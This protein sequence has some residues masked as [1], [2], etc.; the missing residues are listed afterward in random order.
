MNELDR[1]TLTVIKA[2]MLGY[3]LHYNDVTYIL[4][5][6]KRLF[7]KLHNADFKPMLGTNDILFISE[8]IKNLTEEEF[9]DISAFVAMNDKKKAIK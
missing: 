4:G 8:V 2:L 7:C 5:R 6:D 1:K 9:F 3:E